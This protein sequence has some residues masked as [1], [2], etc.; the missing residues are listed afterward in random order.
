MP[1]PVLRPS[2][3]SYR[4]YD[5][6]QARGDYYGFDAGLER[7]VD[8]QGK[9][10][11]VVGRDVLGDPSGLLGLAVGV[12]VD[13]ADVPE[14]RRRIPLGSE[15]AEVFAD[16]ERLGELL[17]AVVAE[18]GHEGFGDPSGGVGIVDGKRIAAYAGDLRGRRSPRY[19]PGGI[20]R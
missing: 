15:G 19:R 17:D 4:C 8:D 9:V 11:R 20:P 10:W 2:L 6:N 13:A 5:D 14:Y 7:R 3:V 16:G 1:L 18:V 12:R